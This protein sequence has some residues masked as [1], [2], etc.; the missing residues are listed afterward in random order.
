MGVL[1]DPVLSAYRW[2]TNGEMIAAIAKVGWLHRDWKTVDPTYG[3]GTFWSAWKPEVLLASDLDA[4][5]SPTGTSVDA[6][7]LPY[8]SQSVGAVVLDPPYQLRG[9]TSSDMDVRYGV[10]T[11]E[12]VEGRHALMRAMLTEAAR[13]VIPGG[14]V[15]MKCQE[16]VCSGSFWDQPYL[17]R[18]HAEAAQLPLEPVDKFLFMSRRGQPERSNCT[19]CGTAIMYRKTGEW[20]TVTRSTPP[21]ATCPDGAP[22]EPE[23]LTQEHSHRN[24][25]TMIIWRA[26]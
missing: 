22:H 12:T 9:T 16:Q 26:T 2:A 15:M 1:E 14:T 5:K 20:M 10:A 11:Y 13:V 4:A 21:T 3:E 6:T 23:G 18:Q 24:Y 8:P 25:S 19:H 17:M 7:N